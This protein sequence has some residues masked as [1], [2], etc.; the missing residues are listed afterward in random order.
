MNLQAE[1]YALRLAELRLCPPPTWASH[2]LASKERLIPPRN[3][4]PVIFK[5]PAVTTAAEVA[6]A[7]NAVLQGVARGQLTPAD[8]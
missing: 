3:E 2:R 7:L 1:D 5:L 8:G 6:A 4:H